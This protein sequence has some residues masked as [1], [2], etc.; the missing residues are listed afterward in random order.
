MVSISE[1]LSFCYRDKHKEK[2]YIISKYNYG[3]VMPFYTKLLKLLKVLWKKL[4]HGGIKYL[5]CRYLVIENTVY[6]LLFL[7]LFKNIYVYVKYIL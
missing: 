2:D 3:H 7:K 6:V 1:A 5:T 4:N